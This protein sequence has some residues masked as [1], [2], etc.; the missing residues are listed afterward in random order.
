M[1]SDKFRPVSGEMLFPVWVKPQTEKLFE[2]RIPD[3][4]EPEC[5]KIYSSSKQQELELCLG[6]SSFWL[7]S[8]PTYKT[9]SYAV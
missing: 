7:R 8:N 1:N 2:I 5:Q 4:Q 3:W 9:S 6:K